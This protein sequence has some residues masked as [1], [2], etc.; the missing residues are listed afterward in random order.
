MMVSQMF[1]LYV[2]PTGRRAF[3]LRGVIAAAKGGGH[4][5]LE[6]AARALLTREGQV[7]AMEAAWAT[8]AVTN[9][10][11]ESAELR[12]LDADLDRMVTGV[13]TTGE[14][15]LRALPRTLRK[16]HGP[17]IQAFLLKY[18]PNGAQAITNQSYP[19][20][21]ESVLA[22]VKSMRTEDAAMVTTLGLTPY[23]D[24][25]EAVLPAYLE[26]IKASG[27]TPTAVAYKSLQAGRAE[28]HEGYCVLVAKIVAGVEVAAARAALLEPI[29]AQEEA[30][31]AYYAR[32]A[33]V[34][35]VDSTTGEPVVT[36]SAPATPA[37]PPDGP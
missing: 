37:T 21:Y 8:A 4:K 30:M 10:T 26:A 7:A 5:E 2:L 22:L 3:A 18:F 6:K 34:Q 24:D 27:K 23:L 14:T 1:D 20:E 25:I 31:R 16:S 29:V 11:V 32:R 13:R 36:P 15:R 12:E 35:D 9:K 17:A 33:V 28:A 19:E